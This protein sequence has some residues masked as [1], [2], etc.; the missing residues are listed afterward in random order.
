MHAIL[1]GSRGMHPKSFW[2]FMPWDCILGH[3]QSNTEQVHKWKG[4]SS[5][6]QDVFIA[7]PLK[8]ELKAADEMMILS[9]YHHM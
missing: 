8:Y 4:V 5:Y 1:E 6:L 2:K 3:F 7:L 9:T